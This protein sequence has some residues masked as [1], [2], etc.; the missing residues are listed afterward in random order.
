[1]L[2]DTAA[3]D[4]YMLIYTSGT[5]GRPKGAVHVHAGFP[6]KAA[7]DPQ[8]GVSLRS[9]SGD[10][11]FWD[12]DLGGVMGPWLIAG[13]LL[14]GGAIVLYDGSIDSPEPDRVW[15]IAERQGATVLG[16]APTAVRGL[17]RQ[18]VELVRRHD[19]SSLRV[20]GSTG[21]PWN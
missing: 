17:M 16:I 1:A 4:P 19:L 7:P 20:L 11:V 8:A 21:E 6:L 14:L 15:A 10:R 5:T 13:V 9:R 12:S 18:P 3:D 2:A